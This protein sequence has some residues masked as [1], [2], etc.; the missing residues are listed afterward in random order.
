VDFDP[1]RWFLMILGLAA[2]LGF[3]AI[4]AGWIVTEAG[5]QPW[6]VQGVLRTRD[7]VTPIADVG[8]TLWGFSALYV[9][10]GVTL[11]IMLRRLENK[12]GS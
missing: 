1:P 8:V 2:P 12:V 3:V 9:A 6:A 11:A 10:L 7:A 4:E 5:R